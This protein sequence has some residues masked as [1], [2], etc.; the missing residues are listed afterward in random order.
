VLLDP[1]NRDAVEAAHLAWLVA[2]LRAGEGKRRTRIG[3][4][5]APS[6]HLDA[7]IH[8]AMGPRDEA[9][10]AAVLADPRRGADAFPWW[11]SGPGDAARSRALRALWFD[12][13]WR[14]PLDDDERAL[15]TRVDAD[16]RV[17]YRAEPRRALPW[18]AWAELQGWLDDD[19]AVVAEVARRAGDEVAT[20]GYRRWPMTVD[21]S[22]GWSVRLPGDM[23]AG[24]D[25]DGGRLWA[26]NGA[27]AVEFVSVT[28]VGQ[29]D[30]AA[31]LA[32]AP[33]RHPVSAHHAAG[34]LCG[35]VEHQ[36]DDDVHLF[37]GIM[38]APEAVA[39]LTLKGEAAD[40]AWA[41]E[42]WRSLR[43]SAEVA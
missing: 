43:W 9:W 4:G 2:R 21:L 6:F 23:V 12:V 31:L 7:P 32:A 42:A 18:P 28:A 11:G 5:D 14:E 40:E 35:R 13:P 10:R 20:I 3:M 29:R 38:A 27:Q 34:G 19:D 1:A 30:P 24:W 25:E 16:L 36:I 37:H 33:E 8:T 39:L 22:G 15:L 17:A 41:I 26:T